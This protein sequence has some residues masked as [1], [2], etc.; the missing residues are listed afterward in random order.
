MSVMRNHTLLA[1]HLEGLKQTNFNEFTL[2]LISL[3]PAS[4]NTDVNRMNYLR[5][6]VKRGPFFKEN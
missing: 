3:E 2:T 4:L 1:M 6:I 5:V